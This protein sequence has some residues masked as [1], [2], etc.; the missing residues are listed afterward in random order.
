MKL[1]FFV[2]QPGWFQAGAYRFQHL[3]LIDFFAHLA[4]TR[5]DI[6]RLALFLPI[7][8]AAPAG[9]A[10]EPLLFDPAKVHVIH[11][12]YYAD[13][14]DL[15][16][17]APR[18]L[19]GFALAV[20][21]NLKSLDVV[22]ATLPSLLGSLFLTLALLAG[23]PAFALIRGNRRATL[24]HT[25]PTGLKHYFFQG[26]T[27]LLEIY[28]RRLAHHGVLCLPMAASLGQQ[29][30][31]PA[32]TVLAPVLDPVFHHPNPPACHGD[33]SRMLYVG[34]LSPE[35][36]VDVLL[37]ACRLLRDRATEFRLELVGDGPERRALQ[38]LAEE[39]GLGDDVTFTGALPHGPALIG[40]YE[41]AG[42][43]VLPSRTEGLPRAL[44]EAMGMGLAPVATA[45]GGIPDLIADGSAGLLVEPDS[46]AALADGLCR[47]ITDDGLR[48]RCAREAWLASS[49]FTFDT[50]G[51]Q[52]LT[53]LAKHQASRAC[54]SRCGDYDQPATVD[55][56]QRT[57]Q[58]VD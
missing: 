50:A 53:L 52:L 54:P 47:M 16:T 57:P 13:E 26:G 18:L 22:G 25:Y 2:H 56:R 49:R 58:H 43:F 31:L 33:G 41:R 55:S 42:V 32:A 20:W 45:V 10:G 36:G 5:S 11:L 23:T 24:R 27:R 37:R 17:R 4:S 35:K 6:C 19:P 9:G 48:A 30:R 40:A 44:L 14:R 21:R 46:P 34:R 39:L 15:A 8:A 12:P 38:A 3:N 1:G 29:L 51:Q 7:A 28:A